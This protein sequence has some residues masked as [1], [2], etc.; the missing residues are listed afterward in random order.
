[1]FNDELMNPSSFIT[2][3]L[4]TRR[5]KMFVSIWRKLWCDVSR[6]SLLTCRC[7]RAWRWVTCH[8]S[9]SLYISARC[10]RPCRV[11]AGGCARHRWLAATGRAVLGSV[12]VA[13]GHLA[14]HSYMPGG[15]TR[16]HTHKYTTVS[17]GFLQHSESNNNKSHTKLLSLNRESYLYLLCS[18]KPSYA[19]AEV[20][21]MDRNSN[22]HADRIENCL[23]RQS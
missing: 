13:P 19:M 23:G 16:I 4:W 5:T 9:H 14:P 1:M 2:L 21:L 18:P 17:T 6:V 15:A 20:G 22:L 3:L 8:V 7:W 11:S 10:G 12:G